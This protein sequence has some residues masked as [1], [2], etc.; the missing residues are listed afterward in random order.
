[1]TVKKQA[2]PGLALPLAALCGLALLAAPAQANQPPVAM[3]TAGAGSSTV[4]GVSSVK[5]L[6]DPAGTPVV[7][8]LAGGGSFDPDGD[9]ITFRWGC[10]NRLVLVGVPTD[11]QNLTVVLPPG[12]YQFT[13]TV[14]DRSGASSTDTAKVEVIIDNVAP[15]V[16]PPDDLTVSATEA[17]GA[18]VQD[19]AKLQKFLFTD[20]YAQDPLHLQ[21]IFS[22][23]PPQVNGV[24]VDNSTLFPVFVTTTVT[25]RFTDGFGNVGAATADLYVTDI[26]EGDL[27]VR[28]VDPR[29]QVFIPPDAGRVFQ[30][31]GNA[32]LREWCRATTTFPFAIF[33]RGVVVD[34]AGRVYILDGVSHFPPFFDPNNPEWA[35]FRCDTAGSAPVMVARF[36]SI[37][38]PNPNAPPNFYTL[39]KSFGEFGGLHLIP[40]KRI[41]I[42]DAGVSIKKEDILGLSALISSIGLGNITNP[43]SESYRYFP[44]TNVWEMGPRIPSKTI[45]PSM[46]HHK[47]VTYS[48]AGALGVNRDPMMLDVSGNIAG[49][50]FSARFQLFGGYTEWGPILPVDNLTIPN[51]P[52]ICPPLPP[53]RND[54]PEHIMAGM[55]KVIFDNS[56]RNLGLVL[57]NDSVPSGVRYFTHVVENLWDKDPGNDA[58]SYYLWIHSVA[59]GQPPCAPVPGIQHSSQHNGYANHDAHGWTVAPSGLMATNRFSGEIFV[60]EEAQTTVLVSGLF[61]PEGIGAWPPAPERGSGAA[62]VIRIDS[63]VDVL[64][65]DA[66]GKRIGVDSGGNA[67]NDF[68]SDGFD[69]G[70]G[71]HPR[72]Y[73]INDPAPGAFQ[74]QSVGTGTGPFTVHIYSADLSKP[75]GEHIKVMGMASPGAIGKHDFMLDTT[76]A[77]AFANTPPIAEAGADQTLTADASGNATVMLDGSASIDP[78]A[79]SLTLT[80]AGPFGPVNGAQPHVTLPVGVHVL[81]LTVEDGKG[82]IAKDTVTIT[83]DDA[84]DTSPPTLAPMANIAVLAT[85]PNGAM[86]NY[87]NPAADDNMD[88]NPVVVC[89]PASGSVFP[90]GT[91]RVNC[92]AADFSGNQ[93]ASFFDVTVQVGTPRLSGRVVAKGR[94]AGGNYFVDV[95]LKNTGTGH[96]RSVKVKTLALRTLSGT[97]TVTLNTALSPALPVAIGNLDVGATSTHRFFLSVP[98][99]VTRFSITENGTLTNVLG[100]AYAFSTAQAVTP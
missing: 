98:S 16:I 12:V 47:G 75:F 5:R 37:Y 22:Q 59:I 89:A 63:P 95:Q 23:L 29:D 11:G 49:A 43:F 36:P 7:H 4:G 69:S 88:P 44:S 53:H 76:G 77:L 85:G 6:T 86:V 51:G 28:T 30:V 8:T 20:P 79:D 1:V 56:S 41:V 94:D 90:I 35:L 96:A 3:A 46:Y 91:T 55:L 15:K 73:A 54:N 39:T 52:A 33:S 80:W 92:L 32:V 67:V 58:G 87:T 45:A 14:M 66:N 71:S 70:P 64:V 24:D 99:T 27:F 10:D 13:L 74:V 93:A 68:G 18:R 82:G 60:I 65:T 83:V 57:Q 72:I 48:L 81:T 34:S 31:R 100:T 78:D 61:R 38:G 40:S 26:Q 62:V 21:F 42:D 2:L 25:F 17:G 9:P 97:G 84:A 50:G 19:S